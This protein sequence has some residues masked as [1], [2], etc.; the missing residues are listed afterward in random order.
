MDDSYA[1]GKFSEKTSEFHRLEYHCADVAACFLELLADPILENRVATASGMAQL[2]S[3]TRARL[4][5]IAYLHDYGKVNAGFQF[6]VKRHSPDSRKKPAKAGHIKES[7]FFLHNLQMCEALNLKALL[8]WGDGSI[9]LLYA[10]LAHHG[11]PVSL[12]NQTGSSGPP[13]LWE[14]AGGYD[15]VSATKILEKCGRKWFAEAFESTGPSLPEKVELAHL[16]CGLVT[17]ADQIG[18]DSDCFPFEPAV[19]PDYWTIARTNAA[20]AVRKKGFARRFWLTG[21][22]PGDTGVQNL[23]GYTSPRAAQK[24]VQ[25]APLD[26]KLLILESETGSGK[27]EAAILRFAALWEAGIVDGL[28]FALP[29]RA[30]AKQLHKRVSDAM[31]R[32]L[33]ERDRFE[34]VLAIPGYLKAGEHGG[35]YGHNDKFTV[36]WDDD[37]DD[38]LRLARWA[39]E[40]PRKF[41]SAPVAVG[42]VDQILLAGLRI[43]WAHFRAAS[44]SR[45]LLVI[46]EV[47]ASSQYM[48]TLLR[49]ILHA[50]LKTGGYALVMSATLGATARDKFLHKSERVTTD[51]NN[52]QAY[53][54]PVLTL[55]E[56]V[57]KDPE[58]IPINSCDVPKNIM[59]NTDKHLE[60]PD[61]IAEIAVRAAQAGAK[62]LVIRNTVGSAQS[63]FNAILT[64]GKQNFILHVAD[65]PT[66]HH[67][68]FSVEDRQ[69]LD[70]AVEE[71]LGKKST[72]EDGLIVI[73]TQTLE[74]SLDIDADFLITDL[75][76]MDVLLQ[77]IGRLHRHPRANRPPVHRDPECLVLVPESGLEK[78]LEGGLRQYGMGTSRSGGIYEN[79]V[80]LE[81]TR[82][83]IEDLS[84][85]IVPSM[86]RELV[87]KATHLGFLRELATDLGPEW[88]NHLNDLTGKGSAESQ[89]ARLHSLTRTEPFDIDFSFGKMKNETRL[90]TRLGDDGFRVKLTSPSPGPFRK[91][92]TTFNLPAHMFRS[93]KS[94]ELGKETLESA[95]LESIGGNN[96]FCLTVGDFQFNYGSCGIERQD[97]PKS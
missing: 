22:S 67:S 88:K 21:K 91:D 63:V 56:N 73:G 82:C 18:S 46:D 97:S 64:S 92:V 2:D 4:A 30:A 27:T 77:R 50:H 75:C 13:E 14:S 53:P 58:C 60:N 95:R 72:R 36:H 74:Q 33:P 31:M 76:P 24:A 79:I 90:R 7:L 23:F 89:I 25:E 69:L 20:E 43:K 41:L 29:T 62:V 42:T 94:I 37:P 40:S 87:E 17:L 35:Q 28:Y 61:A 49:N 71:S 48:S 1:W 44:V 34:T 39:A 81:S 8:D 54:Y 84:P 96:E 45:S 85:W 93:S 19:N 32:L 11:R 51:Y 15:P 78:G 47:H 52:A 55:S 59:V 26:S 83:A 86:C 66:L 70:R 9:P 12:S 3:V 5:Y 6:K 68:R 65:Q 16:F 57:A 80:G 10:A 38:E